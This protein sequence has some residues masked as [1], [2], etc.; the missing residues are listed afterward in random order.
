MVKVSFQGGCKEIGRSAVLIESET[1]KDAVL[2]DYGIKMSGKEE[3]FPEHVSG[4]DLSAI[5]ITHSHIDH[6][7]GLPIFYI[8]GNVP[9]YM[10]ELTYYI[11]DVLLRDMM[12]ISD[13]FLPFDRSAI[14]NI[15]RYKQFLNYKQRT[16]VGTNTY[17]T[18][19]NS[20]HIPGSAMVLVEMDDKK[21]LYTGD[22]NLIPTQLM[23]PAVPPVEKLDLLITESTYGTIDHEPREKVEKDFVDECNRILENKG[24]VLVPAFG[25]SRSQ[26]VLMVLNKYQ[27][28][29]PVFT[30]GMARKISRIY[31]SYHQYFR[32]WTEMTSALD[33]AQFISQKHRF[34][35][36][37]TAK[38]TKSGVI[39]APSG[40][41]KGGT[42]RMYAENMIM[43]PNSGI[44]LV[45]YQLPDSP[46]AILI[47]EHKYQL[48]PKELEAKSDV[49]CNVKFFDFSSHCGKTELIQFAERC[50]FANADKRVY[51][52][53]GE[54]SIATS[55]AEELKKRGFTAKAADQAE[56]ISI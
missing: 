53:H 22:F 24:R 5:V 33:K 43:D 42:A 17:I 16:K 56:Q 13:F 30:D 37:E 18:L 6:V 14:D 29:F 23:S 8:S 32:S 9:V 36:R 1:T 21:V 46:G 52:V 41:L 11:S 27:I 4:K 38:N 45:S 28:K 54:S 39:V 50:Q 34:L 51:V 20:G 7:G 10:T 47:N 40:M 55:F 15:G 48:N 12:N 3:N 49:Y 44:F 26:E 31:D 2:L 19:L 35:D 25:V